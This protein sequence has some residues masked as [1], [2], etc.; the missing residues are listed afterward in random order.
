LYKDGTN[1]NHITELGMT[2]A[3]VYETDSGITPQDALEIQKYMLRLIS[4]LPE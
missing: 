2:N 1:E 3:D 4:E